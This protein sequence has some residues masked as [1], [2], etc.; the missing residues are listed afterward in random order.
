MV[1]RAFQKTT[2]LLRPFSTYEGS[3]LLC[4]KTDYFFIVLIGI[5][6]ISLVKIFFSSF[7]ASELSMPLY[8]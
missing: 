2:L 7:A 8:S 6:L 3:P 5:A 4:E 1:I